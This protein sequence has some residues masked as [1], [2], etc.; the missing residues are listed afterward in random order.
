M[1]SDKQRTEISDKGKGSP[2]EVRGKVSWLR[3]VASEQ[4]QGIYFISHLLSLFKS[5]TRV[6]G[7]KKARCYKADEDA[8]RQ[9]LSGS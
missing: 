2:C 7:G 4:G 1:Q 9:I 8:N 6:G 5:P 3:P